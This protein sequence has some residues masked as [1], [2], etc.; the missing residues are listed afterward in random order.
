MHL[1]AFYNFYPLLQVFEP[2]IDNYFVLQDT[3]DTGLNDDMKLDSVYFRS[4]G[5]N[6]TATNQT[7]SMPL[8]LSQITSSLSGDNSL[9]LR[10]GPCGVATAEQTYAMENSDVADQSSNAGSGPPLAAV[11]LSP[12]YQDE[13]DLWQNSS[14]DIL[15]YDKQEAECSMGDSTMN[16][17]G[18]SCNCYFYK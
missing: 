16:N 3:L 6:N 18:T 12:A 13:S 2:S 11:Y 1:K 17:K 15:F 4:G 8:R 14:K 9:G 5:G 10:D 7:L